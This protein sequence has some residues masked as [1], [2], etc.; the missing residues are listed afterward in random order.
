MNQDEILKDK[1]LVICPSRGRPKE[2]L[3]MIESFNKTSKMS[4][5]SIALDNDDPFLNQYVDLISDKASFTIDIRKSTTE[6][7][8]SK[9]KYAASCYKWL[10]VSNDD[11][12]YRTDSWDL[13]LLS[14]LKLHGGIGI[15]YG[16]D[17]LA[18]VHIPTTSIVSR[19]IVEALGW[20]QLPTLTHLFGD[21][22]WHTI[23]QKSKCLFYRD[24]V[25][26][27]HM[28][29]F[30]KKMESD[31]THKE[32]NSPDMYKKD[33]AA[34]LSWLFNESKNDIL[35]VKEVVAKKLR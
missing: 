33:E 14:T 6:I 24:D 32:T 25:I 12:I 27:E 4:S 23:G 31:V 22:V 15:V 10:S 19:E 16:N 26:I 28:H 3:R 20:L 5:L 8:N 34:F 13:K 17:L 1:I 9:W 21:N 18:G 30:G 7:I 29:V 35:K 2:C 11:F